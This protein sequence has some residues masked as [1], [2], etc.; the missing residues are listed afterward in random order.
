MPSH[1][2]VR[3]RPS[4]LVPAL[5]LAA[6]VVTPASALAADQSSPSAT[7]TALDP[8]RLPLAADIDTYLAGKGSPM[9][10][11]GAA[12]VASGSRWGVDP[13]LL[14]AIAGGESSFGQITC[15]PF[16][17]WGWGC[18]NGPYR[19]TSWADGI[20]AVTRGLRTGYLAEGRTTV[21]AIHA[22]Y[23]PIGAGNDPTGLNNNWT[24]NVSR[25][26]TELGG[27]PQDVDLDG[28]AGSYP[29]G[30]GGA[31]PIAGATF[32]AQPAANE[33]VVE[34]SSGQRVTLTV[35]L[36]NSGTASW[37]GTSVRVRR[38]DDEELITSSPIGALV[39]G[40]EVKPGAVGKFTVEATIV[41]GASGVLKTRWQLEGPQ[42]P[43]GS[44]AT[45]SVEVVTAAFVAGGG[46]VSAPRALVDTKTGNF[47]A[48]FRNDGSETWKRDGERAVV[49][50]FDD[51]TGPTLTQVQSETDR[52]ASDGEILV[53][54]LES[55]VKPGERAT[56]AWRM[57]WLGGPIGAAQL[58]V[59]PARAPKSDNGEPAIVPSSANADFASGGSIQF[60]VE[61]TGSTS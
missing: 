3:L 40:S 17:A 11:Q 59:I 4:L 14:V 56:F 31:P 13:R 5:I 21:A 58:S 50:V 34:A 36:R 57:R 29:V 27:D 25:F 46:T 54:M 15:A 16:N 52:P 22:K 32:D 43:A 51:H 1:R 35:G 47:I 10:G 39:A 2:A 49:L 38:V 37:D 23:A 8:A 41:D 26:L 30:I 28:V 9:A 12:F 61:V 60:P 18:P 45:A 6:L 42:G 53:S 48:R 55:V 33:P 19:F 24:I 7:A 20:E 44:E